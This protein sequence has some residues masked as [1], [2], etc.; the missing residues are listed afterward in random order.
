MIDAA[1]LPL[2]RRL[3]E[4]LAK[5]IAAR[6]ISA[7]HLTLAGFGIGLLAIPALAFGSYGVA[8]TLIALNRLFDGLDGAVA[9]LTSPTDRGAFLDIALDFAFYALVPL[10]F[11]LAD[12]TQNALP[13]AVLIA[14][15]VGTGSSFLAFAVIAGQR[16]LR[17]D[18]YPS[19]GIYY[20]GG[21]TEGAET[22]GLFVAMCLF[23]DLFPV[24]AL[25]FA[26]ACAITTLTR[27]WQGWQA[28]AQPPV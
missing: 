21:L 6:G 15:F 16:G 19:K 24:L 25:I 10:G 5:A 14:A 1:L 27:W 3:L 8:L 17:P 9:R 23:P 28:F 26:A 22:I 12:P 11:A 13:A 2:Q 20:L 18:S 7:D 4:P